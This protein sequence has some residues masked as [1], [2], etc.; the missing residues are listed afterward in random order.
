MVTSVTHR[1]RWP[2]LPQV[3]KAPPPFVL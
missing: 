2:F 1:S 3:W